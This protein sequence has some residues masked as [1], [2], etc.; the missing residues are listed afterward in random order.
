MGQSSSSSNHEPDLEENIIA[1]VRTRFQ[2]AAR[3]SLYMD[4]PLFQM[5][6]SQFLD[7]KL[8]DI[9]FDSLKIQN[10][11]VEVLT[12]DS[13]IRAA[14]ISLGGYE[15]QAEGIFVC[16]KPLQEV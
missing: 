7:P 1:T 3:G 15:L 13:F 16:A 5:M 4:K 12:E 9:L 14:E 10:E 2:R 8:Q 6:S 11:E